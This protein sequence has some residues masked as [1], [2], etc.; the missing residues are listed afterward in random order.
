MEVFFKYELAEKEIEKIEEYCNSVDYFA[1]EQFIG[2]NEIFY[3]SKICYFYLLDEGVIK[4]FSQITEKCWSAQISLGPVCCDKEMMVI[5]LNEIIH[6]YKKKYFYYLGIQMYF[7][8]GFDLDYIDYHINKHH[9]IKYLFNPKNTKTSIE[10][11][12]NDSIEDIFGRFSSNHKKSI[13]KAQKM[14][15]S[16]QEMKD[17]TELES[18]FVIFSKMYKKRELS[19][20]SFTLGNRERIFS[21]LINKKKGKFLVVKDKD[22]IMVGGIVLIFQ[23]NTVRMFK[24]ASDPERREIPINHLLV[25]EIIKIAKDAGFKYLD[26]WGYNHFVC[27]SDQVYHINKFKF[28][29][30]GYYTFF[31]KKMNIQLIPYGYYIFKSLMSLKKIFLLSSH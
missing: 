16:V 19:D 3:K 25:Y 9:N 31:A 30:G 27:K 4:S 26:L 5:T 10:I 23:G 2:W 7:K 1:A 17:D 20:D 11:N 15:V 6:Y 14:G 8:S 21:Y 13:R 24:G 18:L 29:F 28:E 12:L 22:G